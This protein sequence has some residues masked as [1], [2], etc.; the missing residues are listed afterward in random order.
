MTGQRTPATRVL[1]RALGAGLVGASVVTGARWA[2]P[3]RPLPAPTGPFLVGT[4]TA[5]VPANR[6]GAPHHTERLPVQVWYPTEA[7]GPAATLLADPLGF[8]RAVA[9]RYP[10]HSSVL[11]HLRWVRG[12]AVVD[13][14]PLRAPFPVVVLVHG[15]KGFRAIH[16]DLA[17]QLASE[18]NVV[19][20]ADHVGGALAAQFPGGGTVPLEPSL[21][22]PADHPAYWT[23]AERL[24][25]TFAGDV[26]AVLDALPSLWEQRRGDV[27]LVA[28]S[29]GGGAAVVVAERDD[30]VGRLVAMDPWV[31]PVPG[32]GSALAVPF[33]AVR[34][35]A[36]TGNRNDERLAAIRGVQLEALPGSTHSDFTIL[37]F[38][39]PLTRL[40]GMTALHPA[41]PRAA[42]LRAIAAVRG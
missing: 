33:V 22:P 11:T 27:T 13:A 42:V 14:P 17:E 32:A 3:L 29:T 8:A 26:T 7:D 1:S 35:A 30:R 4:R 34:S 24:V 18:G 12:N 38:L 31:E 15:W 9:T 10:V 20:A 39:S 28:H 6:N 5:T 25:H 41:R 37:G 19:V 36:W 23:S 16:A 21:L 40:A 2:L